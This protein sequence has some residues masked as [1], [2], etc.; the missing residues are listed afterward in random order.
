MKH[1]RLATLAVILSAPLAFAGGKPQAHK[2]KLSMAKARAIALAKIPG[3]VQSQELEHAHG[4]WVYA[5]VIA[6]K[7]GPHDVVSDIDV[8]AYRGTVVAFDFKHTRKP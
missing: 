3:T 7:G 4:R 5:F 2:G 8:D 6:P 1:L